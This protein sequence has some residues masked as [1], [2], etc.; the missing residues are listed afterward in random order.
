MKNANTADSKK[1]FNGKIA[2]LTVLEVLFY[3][4]S[5]P[6]IVVLSVVFGVRAYELVPYYSFWPFVGVI[7]AGVLCLIFIIVVMCISLRKKSKRTILMQTVSII[8]AVIF[9]TSFIAVALDVVLPDVLAQLTSST[10]FYEDLN[11]QSLASEQAEFNASLDRKFIMLNLLNGNYDPQYEYET[12]KA[13]SDITSRRRQIGSELGRLD[14]TEQYEQIYLSDELYAEL[15]QFIYDE[16]IMTDIDYALLEPNKPFGNTTRIAMGHA[17]AEVIYPEFRQLAEE[18][19][20]NER[21]AYLY[22]NNYASLKNDGYL[23]YDDSMI[24]FATSGRMTVPVVIRLLLDRGYTYTEGEQAYIENGEVVEPEGTFYLELYEKEDV[25]A[26]MEDEDAVEWNS[27]GTRGVLVKEVE[28]V[29]YG[30]GAVVIPVYDENGTLTGGYI[31]APRQW[32]ILDMDGKNMDVAAI[33]DVVIDLGELLGDIEVGGFDL[34]SIFRNMDPMT[35][36]ELLN[37]LDGII[38]TLMSALGGGSSNISIMS[39]IDKLLQGVTDVI[40][41]ATGGSGLYL[42]LAINDQGALEIAIAPTNV[43]V[44]MHGYQYMTW[45]ESNNLLFAVMGVMSLREWLYIFGAVSV[46]LAFAAGMC[47][48]IKA[49]VRKDMADNEEL[50]AENE[51]AGEGETFESGAAEYDAETPA[52]DIE[53]TDPVPEPT[54]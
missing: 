51:A 13:D 20:S 34:G 21:I 26:I 40:M 39:I 37:N 7:L 28:G 50:E 22:Q 42:N 32:S 49:R 14:S 41:A 48:E 15:F 46:L 18:G 47:R 33:S 52:A 31:R 2:G 17:I 19:M 38:S 27:D 36:G 12:L 25:I 23:T 10:L 54:E 35:I 3:L 16:Y 5:L 43:E 11:N 8:V 1:K 29:D 44:G 30:V 6:I 53:A 4:F 24:L 45:M 9:L